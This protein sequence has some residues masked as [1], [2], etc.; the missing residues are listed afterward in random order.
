M[1]IEEILGLC[2]L[3]I[4]VG[5][6]IFV[7]IAAKIDKLKQVN[8]TA[9]KAKKTIVPAGEDRFF[10]I[11][12]RLDDK[13]DNPE[14]YL[15]RNMRPFYSFDQLA[16]GQRYCRVS[17]LM[18]QKCGARQVLIKDALNVRGQESV[19]QEYLFPYAGFAHFFEA[20]PQPGNG[21]TV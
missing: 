6:V 14:S 2:V 19:Q 11:P 20:Q 21:G 13:Y 5:A 1:E 7:V 17:V 4:F 8:C 9:C 3:V 16:L 18:C 10:A 15:Q 12:C